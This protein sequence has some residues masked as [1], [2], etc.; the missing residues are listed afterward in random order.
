MHDAHDE[1]SRDGDRGMVVKNEVHHVVK[2]QNARCDDVVPAQGRGDDR[3]RRGND[4]SSRQRRHLRRAQHRKKGRH[5][6][7]GQRGRARNDDLQAGTKPEDERHENVGGLH[8]RQRFCHH[9]DHHVVRADVRHV[10]CKPEERQNDEAGVGILAHEEVADR[11][12]GIGPR[13]AGGGFGGQYVKA[14]R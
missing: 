9:A 4:C 11:L 13:E 5:Q 7:D 1:Q 6:N 2:P 12:E 3:R 14:E 8:V 10:G